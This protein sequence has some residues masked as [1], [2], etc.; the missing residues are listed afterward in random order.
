MALQIACVYIII[1]DAAILT[2]GHCEHVSMRIDTI[3][4]VN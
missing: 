3:K 4:S 2:Y 1:K